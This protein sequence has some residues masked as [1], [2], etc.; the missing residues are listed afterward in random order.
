MA[1]QWWQRTRWSRH[2][3]RN[4]RGRRGVCNFQTTSQ[5]YRRKRGKALIVDWVLSD[6]MP[7][8]Q[9]Y[10]G[11]ILHYLPLQLLVSWWHAVRST[12]LYVMAA[13]GK[14]AIDGIILFCFHCVPSLPVMMV[15]IV[16]WFNK[17][18]MH[19]TVHSN[20]KFCNQETSYHLLL[21]AF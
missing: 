19:S 1:K 2:Q 6:W 11:F 16:T 15:Q 14:M 4:T 5:S 8:F 10:F 9:P 21:D 18:T 3:R 13:P 20:F 12:W 17:S 7:L